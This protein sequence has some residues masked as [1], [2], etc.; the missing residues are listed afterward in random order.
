MLKTYRFE[1]KNNFTPAEFYKVHLTQTP[2]G[3]YVWA[4]VPAAVDR[5]AYWQVPGDHS[6]R[7]L[8]DLYHRDSLALF[9]QYVSGSRSGAGWGT[10]IDLNQG[11]IVEQLLAGWLEEKTLREAR[12]TVSHFA[13]Y[14]TEQALN[15][16]IAFVEGGF[17]QFWAIPHAVYHW[18][19]HLTL[20]RKNTSRSTALERAFIERWVEFI[21][22]TNSALD[23]FEFTHNGQHVRMVLDPHEVTEQLELL[24]EFLDAPLHD[25]PERTEA[26]RQG[27]RG[28][29]VSHDHPHAIYGSATGP[30]R[31]EPAAHNRTRGTRSVRDSITYHLPWRGQSK[32][33]TTPPPHKRRRNH[34]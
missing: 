32:K 1:N 26:H 7:E 12:R 23:D 2:A 4:E 5:A 8:I 18:L 31:I 29:H 24:C 11:P 3:R 27:I 13:R 22:D 25:N 21:V 17:S 28:T 19:L 34:D 6:S 10:H 14:M 15:I 16:R 9:W 30:A 20:W 33:F